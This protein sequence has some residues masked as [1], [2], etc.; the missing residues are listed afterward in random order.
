MNDVPAG[1]VPADFSPGFL[2]LS[3]PYYLGRGEEGRQIGLRVTESHANYVGVA[4]GGVLAT[5][6][7]VAL[8]FIVHDSER[9]QLQVVSNSLTVNFLSGTRTGDWLEARCRLDRKGKRIA[10]ASG[11]IRRGNEVVMTMTGVYTILASS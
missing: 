8:S 2:H 1:F 6:A 4:H 11:E 10:Y 7:D 5:F 3:G 9:P